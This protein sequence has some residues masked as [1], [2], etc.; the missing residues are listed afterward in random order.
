MITACNMRRLPHKTP[1]LAR[2][3]LITARANAPGCL[4]T[5]AAVR[6]GVHIFSPAAERICC[7]DNDRPDV[8][9]NI[10]QREW[11]SAC[12]QGRKIVRL[13]VKLEVQKANCCVEA[14]RP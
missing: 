6:P 1:W 7:M 11:F 10:N 8:T 4:N 3:C 14:T 5:F 2:N 13:A 9:S 12:G